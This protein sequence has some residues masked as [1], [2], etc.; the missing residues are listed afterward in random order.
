M[1]RRRYKRH[2]ILISIISVVTATAINSTV[3]DSSSIFILPGGNTHDEG[4]S[5]RNSNGT[6]HDDDAQD[7]VKVFGSLD[8]AQNAVFQVTNDMP[9]VTMQKSLSFQDSM[10]NEK[11]EYTAFQIDDTGESLNMMSITGANGVQR[12]VG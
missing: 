4:I 6:F 9:P 7:T 3:D 11:Y 1:I 12:F 5:N 2:L 10:L 8:T